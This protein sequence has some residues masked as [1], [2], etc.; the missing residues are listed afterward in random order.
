MS[1]LSGRKPAGSWETGQSVFS[2][3]KLRPIMA[4]VDPQGVLLRLKNERA[5][6]RVRWSTI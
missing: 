1:K 6:Y 4:A 5:E 2:A 3:G